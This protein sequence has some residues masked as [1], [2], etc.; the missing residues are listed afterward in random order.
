MKLEHE[1][2]DYL[3]RA[4]AVMKDG[5]DNGHRGS[6]ELSIALTETETAILWLEQ[7]IRT[8]KRRVNQSSA[9]S[10]FPGSR[11]E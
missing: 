9:A 10:P 8:K 6:R 11:T 2:L 3:G 5:R 1:A 4:L 7:D